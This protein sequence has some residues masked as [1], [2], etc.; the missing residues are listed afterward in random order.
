M[1]NRDDILQYNE[2]YSFN[3][4][5]LK[6]ISRST[7]IKISFT[8][9]GRGVTTEE[10]TTTQH[11]VTTERLLTTITD[12]TTA[13]QNTDIICTTSICISIAAL[14][15][16]IAFFIIVSLIVL[17]ALCCTGR[18]T[19]ILPHTFHEKNTSKT[20]IQNSNDK[21]EIR[22]SYQT[23]SENEYRTYKGDGRITSYQVRTDT[24]FINESYSVD[25]HGHQS[26]NKHAVTS[27]SS[28]SKCNHHPSAEYNIKNTKN[29]NTR[30]IRH[31]HNRGYYDTNW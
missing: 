25:E 2:Y 12:S 18:V 9:I 28:Q 22:Q 13:I 4:S 10:P 14:L 23:G 20:S 5:L 26:K 31:V 17:L 16:L 8:F 6:Y 1:V 15:S 7:L 21:H 27:D 29:P 11:D 3:K 30:D 24:Q 19:C